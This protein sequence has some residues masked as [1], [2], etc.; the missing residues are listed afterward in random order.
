MADEART[1]TRLY[2]VIFVGL[3]LLTAVTV[4]VAYV[5]LQGANVAVAIVI[6][7]LKAGL[8]VSVFMHARHSGGLVKA[9]M[10]TACLWAAILIGMT[11]MEFVTRQWRPS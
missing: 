7:S 9:T 8:V 2:V 3:L 10:L 4:A 11:L 5:D 1:E 6:A